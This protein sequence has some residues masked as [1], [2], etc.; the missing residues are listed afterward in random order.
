[1]HNA[2]TRYRVHACGHDRYQEV[3]IQLQESRTNLQ[4]ASEISFTSVIVM[5][6]FE[7]LPSCSSLETAPCTVV[8]RLECRWTLAVL[9]RSRLRFSVELTAREGQCLSLTWSRP[10]DREPFAS[11]LARSLTRM[12]LMQT[13]PRQY[14][15]RMPSRF[16]SIPVSL[17]AIHRFQLHGNGIHFR[18]HRTEWNGTETSPFLWR[19]LYNV[20]VNVV[21]EYVR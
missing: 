20:Y 1:M 21:L 12:A 10:L 16:H 13:A 18:L 6:F 3:K 7:Y 4:A 8:D 2:S 19:L 11:R 15:V 17:N 9:C 14:S 5:P